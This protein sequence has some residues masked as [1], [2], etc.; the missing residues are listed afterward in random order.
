MYHQMYRTILIPVDG[1]RRAEAILNHL[2]KLVQIKDATVVLLK[3]DETPVALDRDEVI[4][5]AKYQAEFEKRKKQSLDYLESLKS[6]LQDKGIHAE[7]RLAHGLV[8]KTIL[9][10]ATDIGADL[11]AIATHGVSGSPRVSYGSTAAGV[12]QA[13]DIPILLIRS[14]KEA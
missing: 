2:E 3:V 8:V 5:L 1:S 14:G 12:L 7:A 11:I 4:D 10:T 6:R 13:A 9:A